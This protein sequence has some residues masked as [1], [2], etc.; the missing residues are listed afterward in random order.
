MRRAETFNHVA[1]E[2][3]EDQ[4]EGEWS[5][6]LAP[7]T[8]VWQPGLWKHPAIWRIEAAIHFRTPRWSVARTE[9][10]EVVRVDGWR[11]LLVDGVPYV[12]FVEHWVY[13]KDR[14]AA[15]A[16]LVRDLNRDPRVEFISHAVVYRVRPPLSERT[17]QEIEH[18]NARIRRTLPAEFEEKVVALEKGRR[19]K[20]LE[21]AI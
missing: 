9:R 13:A 20:Q 11:P 4:R 17:R 7:C 8:G 3:A 21:I 16:S 10:G 5:R 1:I 15:I 19:S 18:L 2:L 12:E 14:G 6:R